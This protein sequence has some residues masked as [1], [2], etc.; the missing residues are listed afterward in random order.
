MNLYRRFLCLNISI[1]RFFPII[2]TIFLTSCVGLRRNYLGS[3][4]RQS[5]GNITKEQILY[6][7]KNRDYLDHKVDSLLKVIDAQ[8]DKNKYLFASDLNQLYS[9]FSAQLDNDR[10][11]NY[12]LQKGKIRHDGLSPVQ[13]YAGARLLTAAAHYEQQYQSNKVV[14][15]A[16]DAG[17]AGNNIPKH[18]LR[19]SR[20]FLYSPIVRKRLEKSRTNDSFPTDSLLRRLPGTNYL[21]ASYY[22]IYNHADLWNA[23]IHSMFDV[24]GA[25]FFSSSPVTI[26]YRAQREKAKTLLSVL[27]PGDIVLC[28]SDGFLTNQVI[29]GF[30]THSAVWLG[31]K[32]QRR[33]PRN[34]LKLNREYKRTINISDN[35]MVEAVTRGGVQLNDLKGFVHP[36]IYL[37]IR[38][39][40]L[41]PELKNEVV[42][43][44]LKQ[45][46]K[47]YDFNFDIESSDMIN[48][49]ELIFLAYDF[50][51]WETHYFMNRYTIFPDDILNTALHN[52]DFEVVALYNNGNLVRNPNLSAISSLMGN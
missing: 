44:T 35:A 21:K 45:I 34:P 43:N 4:R 30:F 28:K 8:Q 37:V 15:R 24:F 27:K 52:N 32:N 29:P 41:T 19:K 20:K 48:C 39:R 22:S 6:Q 46:G 25:M 16:L 42:N 3:T 1:L 13:K 11:F 7:Q 2:L 38:Y 18:T 49:T 10:F 51:N 33:Y 36:S 47:A 14:R 31:L 50:I 26:E 12:L 9:N 17:D 23:V 5:I 40:K